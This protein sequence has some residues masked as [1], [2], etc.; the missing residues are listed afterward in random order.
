ME[1]QSTSDSS[2]SSSDL[3]IRSRSKLSRPRKT[4]LLS[5]SNTKQMW[6]TASKNLAPSSE[7]GLSVASSKAISHVTNSV[8]LSSCRPCLTLDVTLQ[9]RVDQ[10][11]GRLKN[12]S[13]STAIRLIHKYQIRSICD[14]YDKVSA[15]EYAQLVYGGKHLQAITTALEL[16]NKECLELQRK[17]RFDWLIRLPHR[18]NQLELHCLYEIFR[19]NNINPKDFVKDLKLVLSEEDHKKNCLRIWGPPDTCK[20]LISK[21][22]CQTF[23]C[24]YLNN[25]NSAN[26][27]YLSNLLNK[28][29]CSMEELFVTPSSV[30][31]F[32]SILAGAPI[33]ISKKFNEK[34]VLLRT[35]IIMTS[36]HEL[37][38]RR[39]LSPVD[40]NALSTRC[41]MYNFRCSF[42]PDV[43]IS[44]DSFAYFCAINSK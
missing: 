15:E 26:E 23:I 33:D 43:T 8:N 34:Q 24:A 21:L 25:S 38:G 12:A 18:T 40:E 44:R 16:Y 17:N 31:D 1:L 5:S 20:T 37:F 13:T 7:N 28:S 41:Y 30:D 29:L 42:K 14:F 22:I 27:F 11:S 4:E 19:R 9:R 3:C 10:H 39:H 6:L 35:P 2:T 32:K 36:N